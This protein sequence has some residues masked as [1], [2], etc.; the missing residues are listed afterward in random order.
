MYRVNGLILIYRS[1]FKEKRAAHDIANAAGAAQQ[2]KADGAVHRGAP[3]K[4]AR[5]TARGKER[6]QMEKG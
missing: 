2:A 3:P 6:V 5:S 1:P 4:D